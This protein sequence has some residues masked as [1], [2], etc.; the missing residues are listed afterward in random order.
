MKT[1]FGKT[2][3]TGEHGIYK[4]AFRTREEQR[5][6][7]RA[8]SRPR[9]ADGGDQRHSRSTSPAAVAALTDLVD[10]HCLGPSHRPHR[11]R[12]HRAPHPVDPPHRRQPGAARPRRRAAP[13]L[14]RRNR[15][16]QRHRRRHR[17]R[18]GPDQDACSP[19][20]ACRC[21][22][23]RWC[24]APTQ[25]WE[26]AQDIGL[27]VVVKPYDGNHGR[28]VSLNLMTE[29]D[30]ARR[31]RAS[32]SRKGDSSAVLVERFI[33]GNEHRLLVVGQ[34][35]VAAARGESLWVTG[36]GKSTV[37][38]TVRQPDQH[39]PAP[40]RRPRNSRSTRSTPQTATRSC[41]T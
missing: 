34:Q 4:M 37:D 16:H 23:A 25:A 2:R 7:R 28:G 18:Q 19:R 1:G 41:S 38:R 13:H 15:P 33:P 17:Q 5:R 29:A 26:E 20:A 39:R 11:R 10:R 9:T 21:R 24:A 32:P 27:P 35:V 12:R 6:P 31:L 14:D 40:R 30:V 36:D 22:K 3:S 8:G